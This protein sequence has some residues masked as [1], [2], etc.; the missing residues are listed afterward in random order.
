MNDIRRTW[1]RGLETERNIRRI[2]RELQEIGGFG[3]SLHT[4]FHM[5]SHFQ[6][7]YISHFIKFSVVKIHRV[8]ITTIS[9]RAACIKVGRCYECSDLLASKSGTVSSTMIYLV[10]WLHDFNKQC[11]LRTVTLT[12]LLLKI[13]INWCCREGFSW[14][15]NPGNNVRAVAMQCAGKGFNFISHG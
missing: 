15:R 1:K 3:V 7:Y 9:S 6:F 13:T 5:S 11:I 12:L 2:W 14:P 4:S 8:K 10:S